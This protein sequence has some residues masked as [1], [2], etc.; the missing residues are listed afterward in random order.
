MARI[1]GQ[2]NILAHEYGDIDHK[3]VWKVIKV[4]IPELIALLD[5]VMPSIPEESEI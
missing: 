5:G 4:Y 2:R 1:I 3:I